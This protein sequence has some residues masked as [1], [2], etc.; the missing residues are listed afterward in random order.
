MRTFKNLDYFRKVSPEHTRATVIGGLI[1]ILS[2]GVNYL[3]ILISF[4]LDHCDSVLLSD[5]RL[6]RCKDIERH[7]HCLR[8]TLGIIPEYECRHSISKCTLLQ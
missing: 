1:S 7:V 3:I 2:L 6:Y 5:K 4:E 8:P